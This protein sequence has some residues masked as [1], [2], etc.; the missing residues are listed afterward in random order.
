MTANPFQRFLGLTALLALAAS[1]CGGAAAPTATPTK[2]PAAASTAAAT[3]RPA[4]TAPATP[5]A[6]PAATATPRPPAALTPTAAPRAGAKGSIVFVIGTRGSEVLDAH[7]ERGGNERPV[8]R[9][10]YESLGGAGM[11]RKIV[12][13]LAESWEVSADGLAWTWHLRKGVKFHSGDPFDAQDAKFT[14]ERITQPARIHP[15]GS[16][17]GQLLDRVDAPDQY[18]V[19]WR[20]KRPFMQMLNHELWVTHVSK[21]YLERSGDEILRTKPVGTG[22][23][24][25]VSQVKGEFTELE[26]FEEHYMTPPTVKKV[27]LRLVPEDFTRVAMLRTGEAD[28]VMGIP[29]S[30]IAALEKI[31]GIQLIEDIGGRYHLSVLD[32]LHPEASPL[33]DVRVREAISLALD[34][35]AMVDAIYFG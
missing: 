5:G 7:D 13:Q 9:E 17:L 20:L 30:Q 27:T 6:A 19:V 28:I 11:E 33:K 3:P 22:P 2:A 15:Q 23:F 24:K 31:P 16:A 1:A 26:A 18:T 25:F 34:R 21:R 14:V 35:K 8:T 12:P 4:A 29:G 10:I 32:V